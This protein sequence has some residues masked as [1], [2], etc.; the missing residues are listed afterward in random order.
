MGYVDG[1]GAEEEW[2]A[3]VGER[4]DVGGELGDHGGEF[5]D[6]AHSDEGQVEREVDV[7]AAAYG[8]EDRLLDLFGRADGADEQVGLGFVGDD[9]GREPPEMRPMFRVG[10]DL[11]LGRRQRHGEESWSA[12]M[13]LSIADSP[14]SG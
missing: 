7:G 4:G 8:G 14:S 10:T 6:A 12:A 13:S 5:A 2:F 9:V 3:P 1:A 11:R